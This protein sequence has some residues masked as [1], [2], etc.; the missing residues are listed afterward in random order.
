M[1]CALSLSV[2]GVLVSLALPA[3]AAPPA[4]PDQVPFSGSI[5]S[6]TGTVDLTIR[7]YD[8]ALGGTLLYVQDFA[9]V[10]LDEGAFSL[11]LGPTGRATDTPQNPLTTS[12]VAAL[13]GDLAA[14]AP[15]RFVEVT[16]DPSPPLART[17]LL[18]VPFALRSATA[19]SAESADTVAQV[20]G[21]P[22]DVLA[23]IYLNTNLDGGGPPNADPAEGQGDADGDG[24]ANFVDPDNDGDGQADVAEVSQGSSINLVTP[25]I[26]SFVPSAIPFGEQDTVHVQGTFFEPGIAVVFGSQTPAP[27]NVTS[28]G[29]DVFVGPQLGTVPVTVTRL[30]GES[31]SASFSFGGAPVSTHTPGGVIG[32]ALDFDV[33]GF[34]QALVGRGSSYGVDANAD[35]L[36][37]TT[38][39]AGTGSFLA[40]SWTPAGRVAA[41]QTN[42]CGASSLCYVADQDGDL[43]VNDETPAVI[44]TG[45]SP[46]H[47][48]LAFDASGRPVVGY[49][50]TGTG[51]Q[52]MLARDLTGDGDF[53]DAGEV[54]QIQTYGGTIVRRT[55]LAID[56]AGRAAYV[57]ISG[58][59][60]NLRI[61]YDRSGDG[62]FDDTVGG[63]PEISLVNLGSGNTDCLGV[64]FDSA[65]RL[66]LAFQSQAGQIRLSRDLNTDGDL[67]DAGES[68]EI[69]ANTGVCDVERG[70]GG[71]L[72]FVH[73]GASLTRLRD[74]N[75]DGDFG[76]AGESLSL[77]PSS[78]PVVSLEIGSDSW[79]A[80][81]NEILL[82]P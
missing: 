28:T 71:G 6:G 46:Q 24:I 11:A 5:P 25:T 35:G 47:A 38:I 61:A 21:L 62:N 34:A 30:N 65:G 52:A 53:A 13:A 4:I 33:F 12:L 77:L 73:G 67:N 58:A 80:T 17:R 20:G 48:S 10:A 68:T 63:T 55:E 2:V 51:T 19:E 8:A 75:N 36:V 1:R 56:P 18:V 22:P 59:T 78:F 66:A 16:V 42:D 64:A 15:G 39:S 81:H 44:E 9:D 43:D 32:A 45:I 54:I 40:I 27:S 26:T 72:F 7:I 50:R 49:L 70:S 41:V 37:D 3:G 60:N 57:Y 29:F 23:Q 31:D 76:D 69:A 79:I 82:A 14:T 74:L